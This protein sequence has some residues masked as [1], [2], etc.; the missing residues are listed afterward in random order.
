MLPSGRPSDADIADYFY[1]PSGGE[2]ISGTFYGNMGV[3][4]TSSTDTNYP[5]YCY[6]FGFQYNIW[7]QLTTHERNA[8]GLRLW[9]GE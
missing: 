9:T 3:Y 5:N 4:W 8:T 2:Y 6:N 1:L 7:I